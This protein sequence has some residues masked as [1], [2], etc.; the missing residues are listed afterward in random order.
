MLLIKVPCQFYQ[1]WFY[2]GFI[3]KNYF[4]KVAQLVV[5]TTKTE[6]AISLWHALKLALTK[7]SCREDENSE[8]IMKSL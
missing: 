1:G 8:F 3:F 6:H 5:H 4:K 2:L 7:V